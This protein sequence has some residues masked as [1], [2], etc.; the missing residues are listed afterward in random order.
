MY[1][2]Y[3]HLEQLVT[4]S[5]SAAGAEGVA[6]CSS[7]R[8]RHLTRQATSSPPRDMWLMLPAGTEAAGRPTA[9]ALTQRVGLHE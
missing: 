4:W 6:G 5:A 7:Y 8:Q 9:A 2:V 3:L 1:R